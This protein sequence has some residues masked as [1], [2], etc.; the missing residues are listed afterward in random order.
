[1]KYNALDY[2]DS[3]TML[4]MLRGKQMEPAVEC[5]LIAQSGYYIY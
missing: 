2:I 4:E 3:D 1:M 5:I